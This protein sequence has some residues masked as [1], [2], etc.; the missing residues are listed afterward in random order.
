MLPTRNNTWVSPFERLYALQRELDRAFGET[1]T[2]QSGSFVP[3]MDVVETADA[4]L[5]HLEVPG[6]AREDMD[7][8]AEGNIVTVSGEK[9]TRQEGTKESGFR[10]VER[11]Y[12]RFER[13]FAL[14]RTVDPARVKA[15]Y[16]HGVLTIVLPK[17]E[18]SKPRR[19]QIDDGA[20]ASP[21]RQIE[22]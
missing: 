16:E 8:R 11:R 18:Q 9:K 10:S 2:M 17:A 19:I 12:G 4:V 14:P 21:G 7:I 5:C 15:S 6:M 3:P 13:S 1:E 20:P 22:Q